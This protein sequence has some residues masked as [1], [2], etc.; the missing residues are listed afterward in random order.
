MLVVDK[1][2]FLGT[3]CLFLGQFLGAK[4]H[5]LGHLQNLTFAHFLRTN[6][7]LFARF[8]IEKESSI[9]WSQKVWFFQLL[10]PFLLLQQLNQQQRLEILVPLVYR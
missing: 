4:G 3:K 8:R 1:G 10:L 7:H 2:H 5:V 6:A 9:L